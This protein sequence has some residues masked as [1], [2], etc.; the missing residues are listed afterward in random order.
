[1][2]CWGPHI[3]SPISETTP[4]NVMV[5]SNSTSVMR[6]L[7]L[8]RTCASP[9]VRDSFAD[10]ASTVASA[11]C[12]LCPVMG[13]E[14]AT[15]KVWRR[16]FS[17]H[18][19]AFVSWR[20]VAHQTLAAQALPNTHF[21]HAASTR[22][23]ETSCAPCPCSQFLPNRRRSRGGRVA[24]STLVNFHVLATHEI[25]TAG[26]HGTSLGVRY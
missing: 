20:R 21:G 25:V 19:R 14:K 11:I 17:C 13:K 10:L 15:R 16:T 22:Q 1:M 23:N 4:R 8:D 9:N 12:S 24:L 26:K 6:I 2:Q 3:F 5:A 18:P 7:S